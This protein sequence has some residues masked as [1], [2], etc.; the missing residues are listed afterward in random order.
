MAA[1]GKGFLGKLLGFFGTKQAKKILAKQ[2]AK[3]AT[4]AAVGAATSETG[5]GAIIAFILEVIF[6]ISLI[7]DLFKAFVQDDKDKE[8]EENSL[9]QSLRCYR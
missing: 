8:K 9:W 7:Y 5:I 6:G 3:M 2:G 1:G 4:T